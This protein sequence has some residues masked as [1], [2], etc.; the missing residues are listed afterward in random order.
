M[1]VKWKLV[2][3]RLDI[4]LYL[5]QDRCTVF[6]EYTIGLKSFWMD[7]MVHQGDVGQAEAHF[8]PFGDIL[9]WCKICAWFATNVP[10]AWK[11][12]WAPPMVVGIV[13]QV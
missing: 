4:A 3:V 6:N 1:Y 12:L 7:P 5:A 11:L 2:L 8:D 10:L 13:C 9:I